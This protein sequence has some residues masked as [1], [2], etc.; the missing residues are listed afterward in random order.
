MTGSD[1]NRATTPDAQPPA[2]TPAPARDATHGRTRDTTAPRA[3]RHAFDKPAA[4]APPAPRNAF[5][6]PTT[7]APRGNT[8]ND[9]DEDRTVTGG[10][11]H[12]TA[13]NREHGDAR[14]HARTEDRER[15][16][17]QGRVH[18]EDREVT[19]G[20]GRARGG[21]ETHK[22]RVDR[23]LAEL[24]QGLRVAVTGV[25]V[26]FAF[27]FTLPFAAG[28]P[29]VDNLGYWLF[30]IALMS[31]AFASVC[32][33]T[34]AAQHRVLFRSNLKEKMLHRANELGVAGAVFLAV[35]MTSSVAL[36][37]EVVLNAWPAALF[38]AA[39]ALTAGWL[40]LLQ[41]ALDLL[42]LRRSEQSTDKQDSD[43]QDSDRQDTDKQRTER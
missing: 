38:A 23:E 30:F 9:L 19:G 35:A 1:K 41:P 11:E 24:L 17:D 22:E 37:A 6:T 31:A 10:R 34:P 18:A 32:F 29:K 13:E 28:F 4:P 21:D 27:L 14:G 12:A 40:W 25:Q 39:V 3:P 43:R 42:R 20:R 8:G 15:D 2:T 36:V 33:I 7:P 26:L 5:N 16:Y